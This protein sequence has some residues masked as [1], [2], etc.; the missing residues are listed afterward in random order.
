MTPRKKTWQEKIADKNGLPK[1]IKLERGFPC[2][3][4][5]I[6]WA[7]KRVTRSFW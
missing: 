1:F 3:M 7:L 6:K 4:L 5:F 2:L